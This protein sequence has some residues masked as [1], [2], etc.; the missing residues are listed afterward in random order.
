MQTQKNIP[1]AKYSTMRLGGNAAELVEVTSEQELVEAL[2]YAHENNLQIHVVGEGSNTIFGANGFNGLIIVNRIIGISETAENE[3]LV[4]IVGAGEHWD[5]VVALSVERG[6]SDIAA[7]SLI[8]GTTGAAPVQ[9]IGAYGQQ[10]SDSIISVRAYDTAKNEF[11]ELSHNEC[12]F[13]YRHSRFNTV[14]KSR[15]I[16]TSVKMR[17][18]RNKEV[19]PFYKDVADYFDTH[20]INKSNVSP[21][22]LREAVSTV[23]VVKLPDPSMVANCG[24]FFKNPVV[25]QTKYD[26]LVS[27]FPDLKSHKTDDGQLKLYGAQLIELCDLKDV[28]DPHTGMATWKNQALVLVNEQASDTNDLINFKKR[29]TD[30]VYETFGITLV[31]EPEFVELV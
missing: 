12:G 18:S 6:F 1:L 30:A 27:R 25:D 24:S 31:Q 26:E 4:L 13:L 10:V 29:I 19:E 2:G 21:A 22:Q 5:N 11:V 9:N 20:T 3:E 16:I 23:R 17:L 28:H 7:L 14:D 15:F 8:P